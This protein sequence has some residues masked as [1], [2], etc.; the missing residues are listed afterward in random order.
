MSE[1]Q[2]RQIGRDAETGQF[3]SVEYARNHPK[4]CIVETIKPNKGK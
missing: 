1:K 2:K 4:T 3:R